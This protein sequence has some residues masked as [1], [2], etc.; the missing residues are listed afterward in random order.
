MLA[1]NFKTLPPSSRE[2]RICF[3]LVLPHGRNSFTVK[4]SCN[5]EERQTVPLSFI[6]MKSQVHDLQRLSTLQAEV[7][8]DHRDALT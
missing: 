8:L 5:E 6:K 1:A 4:S 2:R 3:S 7:S